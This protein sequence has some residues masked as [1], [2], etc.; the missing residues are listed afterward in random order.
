MTWVSEASSLFSDDGQHKTVQFSLCRSVKQPISA[1]VRPRFPTSRASVRLALT[2][3][4]HW[5]WLLLY[6]NNS[7]HHYKL[8]QIVTRTNNTSK[9]YTQ[10]QQSSLQIVTNCDTNQQHI[11]NIYTANPQDHVV[12]GQRD[13]G[14]HLALKISQTCRF[15]QHADFTQFHFCQI[16]SNCRFLQL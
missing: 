6:S 1:S 3:V 4:C 14:I 15:H 5:W 11:Q 10:Q 16:A 13:G 9:T 7:N 12:Q 2:I 8:W